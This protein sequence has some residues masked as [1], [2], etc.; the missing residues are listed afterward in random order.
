M[1]LEVLTSISACFL[2]DDEL[3]KFLRGSFRLIESGRESVSTSSDLLVNIRSLL[4]DK[5]TQKSTRVNNERLPIQRAF[6]FI[7]LENSGV[8]NKKRCDEAFVRAGA[9]LSADQLDSLFSLLSPDGTFINFS[10][11]IDAIFTDSLD[12][13]MRNDIPDTSLASSLKRSTALRPLMAS[14]SLSFSAQSARSSSTIESAQ[15]FIILTIGF[16]GLSIAEES[17]ELASELNFNFIDADETWHSVASQSLDS[18]QI[19]TVLVVNLRQQ[20]EAAIANNSSLFH[21][22]TGFPRDLHQ[23]RAFCHEFRCARIPL[24]MLFDS[25]KDSLQ[26]KLCAQYAVDSTT[27]SDMI[28]QF[29]RQTQP[30]IDTLATAN[31]LTVIESGSSQAA[32]ARKELL[33]LASII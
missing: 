15:P 21:L 22:I 32:N 7:D 8:V 19:A 23:W 10:I 14:Q 17:K 4:A 25:P 13:T 27:A 26:Q 1:F 12:S 16:G 30:V 6:K 33:K 3:V 31:L 20:I 28:R 9:L 24:I 18:I 2:I 5:L 11:L 29:S